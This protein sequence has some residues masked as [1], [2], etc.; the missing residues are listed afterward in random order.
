MERREAVAPATSAAWETVQCAL[1]P[2]AWMLTHP[3]P[4]VGVRHLQHFKSSVGDP[5][6]G[7]VKK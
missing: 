5:N 3:G 6:A 4:L 1:T 7:S 2:G